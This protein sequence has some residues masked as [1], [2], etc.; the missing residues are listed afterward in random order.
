MAPPINTL[1]DF[2]IKLL[3]TPILSTTLDPPSNKVLSS[4]K[5]NKKYYKLKNGNIIDLM[6]GIIDLNNK[7]RYN[8]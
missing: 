4:L 5:K 7:K 6:D 1:L 8:L 2:S 3:I